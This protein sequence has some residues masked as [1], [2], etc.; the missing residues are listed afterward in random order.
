MSVTGA[1]GDHGDDAGSRGQ[2]S[3]DAIN[4]TMRMAERSDIAMVHGPVQTCAVPGYF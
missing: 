4:I 2:E 1:G 3:L